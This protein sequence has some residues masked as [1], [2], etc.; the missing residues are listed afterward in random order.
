MYSKTRLIRA[1]LPSV[2]SKLTYKDNRIAMTIRMKENNN[3]TRKFS[4]HAHL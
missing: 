4:I 2:M 3:A 1:Y